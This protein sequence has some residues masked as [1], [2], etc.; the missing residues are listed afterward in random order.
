[1]K[2]VVRLTESDLVRLINRIIKE[3]DFGAFPKH[4]LVK[5]LKSKNK[6]TDM[7]AKKEKNK[8]DWYNMN[9]G[10]PYS[11]DDKTLYGIGDSDMYDT[12]EYN[13]YDE[14]LADNPQAARKFFHG[15][16]TNSSR[17]LFN[18]YKDTFGP[19]IV[20]RKKD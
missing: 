3:D 10:S 5:G 14:F 2:K 6:S 7:L 13:T 9:T 15:T 19:M 18:R 4:S 17:M 11:V 16:D 8:T 12:I 1:M 20:K